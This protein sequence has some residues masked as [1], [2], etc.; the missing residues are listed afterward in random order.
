MVSGEPPRSLN[1]VRET[2]MPERIAAH[3]RIGAI[4]AASFDQVFV[5]KGVKGM[6]TFGI[7]ATPATGGAPM[8]SYG[9]PCP[10][11]RPVFT[12]TDSGTATTK[13]PAPNYYV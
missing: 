12:T 1:G 8:A 6:T 4:S 5:L 3:L 2:A 9:D 11:P 10:K 7:L 13:I